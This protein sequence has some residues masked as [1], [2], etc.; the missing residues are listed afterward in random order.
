MMTP[1]ESPLLD[2]MR[3]W[4]PDWLRVLLLWRRGQPDWRELVRDV[5]D[6]MARGEVWISADGKTGG[7]P[8][9]WTLKGPDPVRCSWTGVWLHNA[10]KIPK[11]PGTFTPGVRCARCHRPIAMTRDVAG[12]LTSLDIPSCPPCR[13]TVTRY[14]RS[15]E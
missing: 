12:M 5:H 3:I 11:T 13:S 2:W 9:E 14:I 6:A 15:L 10:A 7:A 8:N 1:E 4:F